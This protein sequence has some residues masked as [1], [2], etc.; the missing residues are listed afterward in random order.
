[1]RG[2]H[3][4]LHRVASRSFRSFRIAANTGGYKGHGD[5]SVHVSNLSC[6]AVGAQSVRKRQF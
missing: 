5:R 1:M 4:T 3:E 2:A 6:D